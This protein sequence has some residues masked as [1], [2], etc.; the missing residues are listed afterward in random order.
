MKYVK[1]YNCI[2]ILFVSDKKLTV[3][4]HDILDRSIC[5]NLICTSIVNIGSQWF[6]P[7]L[8]PLVSTCQFRS[9]ANSQLLS[10]VYSLVSL[11]S[12]AAP[13]QW[14]SVYFQRLLRVNGSHFI[15]RAEKWYGLQHNGPS[16]CCRREARSDRFILVSVW[17]K[18]GGVVDWWL[19]YE[20]SVCLATDSC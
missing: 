19:F 20:G 14:T 9:F 18:S 3:L 11:S 7:I 13:F 6:S 2:T 4:K 16:C 8:L 17:Q 5:L 12:L 15:S 1:L 10:S